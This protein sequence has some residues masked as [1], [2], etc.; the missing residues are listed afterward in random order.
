MGRGP[1]HITVALGSLDPITA[2][3]LSVILQ[4]G[5][6]LEVLRSEPDLP[7]EGFVVRRTPDVAIMDHGKDQAMLARLHA[8]QPS[9]RI[10]LFLAEE[11]RE[12]NVA[13][14]GGGGSACLSRKASPQEVRRVVRLV[15]GSERSSVG[16]RW[17]REYSPGGLALTRRGGDVLVG[18]SEGWSNKQIAHE[19]RLSVRTVEA[20]AAR[21]Q[22]KLGLQRREIVGLVLPDDMRGGVDIKGPVWS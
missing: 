12:K 15:A 6:D 17:D 9:T 10:I 8:R 21:V 18:I 13:W 16:E 11:S 4:E 22:R 1:R 7:F 19:L 3:G 5:E 20:Y 2:C 14:P